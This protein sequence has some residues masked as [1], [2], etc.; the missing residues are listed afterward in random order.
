M[1]HNDCKN[2]STL[3]YIAPVSLCDHLCFL[4]MFNF[5][6]LQST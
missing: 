1:E 5:W 2:E 4:F 3:C 6:G